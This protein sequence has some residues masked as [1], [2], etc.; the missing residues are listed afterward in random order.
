MSNMGH[1]C[2]RKLWYSINTPEDA[3]PLPVEAKVKYLYGDILEELLIYLAKEAGHEVTGEQDEVSLFGVK[4]HRDCIIDGVLVDVKSASSASF[5]RFANHL[6]SSDDGFGY[7]TQLNMYLT[8]SQEDP[9][10][11]TKDEAAF[12]VIDKTL[13]KITLDK[14]PLVPVDYE[15]KVKKKREILDSNTPPPRPFLPSPDGKSGNKKLDTVCSYCEFKKVC[16][17]GLRTFLYSKGP[18]H[19]TTVKRVPDVPEA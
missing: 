5:N 4:G 7:L 8:A 18:V 1:P 2:E 3:E 14:H 17:P 6:T 13:G 16:W 12:L 19:L 11:R 9:L 15:S 10:V